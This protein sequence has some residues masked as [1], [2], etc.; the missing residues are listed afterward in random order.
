MVATILL[1]ED[2]S[3]TR[4]SMAARL[5]RLGHLVLEAGNG[6]ETFEVAGRERPDL[7]IVDWM[8]PEMDDPMFCESVRL[9][10]AI[11]SSILC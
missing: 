2:E 10:P 7:M 3:V 4:A 8:M 1:V 5:K 9:D 11:N 6:R